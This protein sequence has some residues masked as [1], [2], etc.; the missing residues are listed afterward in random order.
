M[1]CHV[2]GSDIVPGVTDL[3]FKRSSATI[4]I[5]KDLPAL[6]CVGC[7][8]YLLDDSVMARVE[9]IL[10]HAD[11]NAPNSRSSASPH[12]AATSPIKR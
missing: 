5:L 10:N 6:Q 7:S 1:K 8:E 2:C 3:P 9:E 11:E 12:D 4:V